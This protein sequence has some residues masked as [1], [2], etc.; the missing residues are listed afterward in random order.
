MKMKC[1]FPNSFSSAISL[2]HFKNKKKMFRS[3]LVFS[4][5]YR[6][7]SLLLCPLCSNATSSKVKAQTTKSETST[8]IVYKLN[9]VDTYGNKYVIATFKTK[10]EAEAECRKLMEVPHKQGYDIE[11]VEL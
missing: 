1:L 6:S 9:R 4:S 2:K 11:A 10:N 7:T 5:F 8:R 3:T